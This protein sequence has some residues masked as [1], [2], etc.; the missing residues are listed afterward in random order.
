MSR[1]RNAKE[2]DRNTKYFHNIASARRRNN[3]FESLEASSTVS[4]RDGLVNRLQREEAEALEV[5]PSAEEVKEAVW[6]CES[7]KAPGNDGY[8]MNFIKKC[9][10]E[11]GSE[12]T[13]AVLSFFEH[14]RLPA[15]S[16]VTWVAL[17]PKFVGAKEIKDL[18]LI[19]MVGCVYKAISKLLKRRMRS[20]M[21]GL[22]GESQSAFVKGR[23]I[24]DGALIACKTVHWLKR[25]RKAAAIIKLDFH[26][27]YDRVKWCF[28]YTVL[29]KMGFER[30]LRQGDPLSRFLFVLVVDVLNRM[31]GEAMRNGR[32]STLLVG[33]DDIELSHLQFVDD[34]ILFCP[35]EEGIVRSYKRLL[36]CFEVMSGLSI[37]FE[38][39]SLI[40]V[41]YSQEWTSRMCQMLGFQEATLPVR[42][43]G[44]SLG[45]NPRLPVYYLSLYKMPNAVARRIISLQR[46]F[47]W[48]KDDG[49]PGMALVKW[50]WHFSKEDCPL[51]K[52]IVCSCNRLN[53]NQLLSTQILPV[54]EGPWR[55]ICHLQIKEQEVRQ[56]MIDGLAIEVGDGRTTKFWE[57]TWL[58]IEKLKDC[59]P[60]LFFISNQKGSPIGDCGFWDRIEWIWHFQWRRELHQWESE[61]LDQLLYALQSVGLIAEVQDRVEATMDEEILRYRFIK[62]IWRGLVPPRVEL[63][64]WFALIGRINTKDRLSRLEFGQ[65]WTAPGTL[66]DH[67]ESWRYMS[68][69]QEV[70][71]FWLVGFFSVIWNIWLRRNDVIFQNKTVGVVECVAQSFLSAAEWCG[72]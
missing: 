62:E 3:R 30:G 9:W 40:P 66:K 26:K 14:A 1:A 21:P 25:Q 39:S 15:D 12:F 34:T 47:F 72:N 2:M 6:D 67:F 69:R 60:R 53:P 32:I 18:R 43:L 70:R 50:E 64:S 10:G 28:F 54:R 33:R 48:E 11:I 19:S 41:N 52:K 23:K 44:I 37:N 59:Y 4:F 63:F 31:I 61:T 8:N 58:Q 56:K 51:W 7:S 71:K 17:A 45:A 57:D 20:V 5:I 29:E 46:R 65:K 24:H 35:P 13:T 22:V 55:D 27:A 38:K 49:R 42:Y 68:M 36:R 16:N